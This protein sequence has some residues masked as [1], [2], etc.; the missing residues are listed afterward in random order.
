MKRTAI[1]VSVC[2]GLAPSAAS[3][4]DWSLRTTQ[5]ETVEL[6]SNQFLRTAPAGSL[7]S[8]STITTNAEAL[9]PTSKFDF[10]ADGSYRKYWGPGANGIPESLNYGFKGRYEFYEKNRSDKEYVEASWRQQSTALALLNQ[11]GVVSNASG[12]LDQLTYSGGLDRSLTAVDTVSLFATSTRTS[13]EPSSGGTPFTD[14]LARGSWRHSLSSIS[15]LNASSE[16]ELLDYENAPKTHVQ[17]Y[18]NQV[19]MDTTLSPVLSF[20]INAGIAY[21]ETQGAAGTT[22]VIGGGTNG[23][24]TAVSDWI[25]NANLTYRILKNTTLAIDASQSIAPSIVGS[26]FKSDI[27]TTTLN[28]TI[29]SRSSLSFS[30]SAYRTI[31][32]TT[33]DSVSASASYSHN[34]TRDLSASLT[35]RY[36]HRFAATGGATTIDPITG[37]PTVSG[38][39]PADSN[40]IMLVVSNSFTILPRGN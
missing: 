33:S 19:G 13:Y 3:A 28:H 14:T 6:N 25:G 7:G 21:L 23:G 9:T 8:Y 37:T 39:G 40:S 34:L 29:N 30:A 11:L 35:Y 31:S 2:F 10:D 22:A 18:R 4:F 26:L 17:I 36:L 1:A 12:F 32:T 16:A 15:A 5:S 20:R 27:V 24:F 38:T